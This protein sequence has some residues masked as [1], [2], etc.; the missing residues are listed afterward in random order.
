MQNEILPKVRVEKM[1]WT[2]AEHPAGL[3]ARV[4]ELAEGKI[5]EALN[6]KD[7]HT[8]IESVE[9]VKREVGELLLTQFPDN[10]KD[11]ANLVG[12]VEY[13]TMRQQVLGRGQRV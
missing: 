3:D 13:H 1:Q 5:T 6:Q 2:K 4:K 7:K 8:R 11:I 9:R 10:A 12:D